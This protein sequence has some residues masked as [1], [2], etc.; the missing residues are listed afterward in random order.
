MSDTATQEQPRTDPFAKARAAKAAKRD[1]KVARG[2]A[3]DK[4]ALA[5]APSSETDEQKRARLIQELA[6]LP[7]PE[8]PGGEPGTYILIG[9]LPG[10]VPFTRRWYE[11]HHEMVEFYP[12]QDGQVILNGVKY[13]WKR[14]QKAKIPAPHFGVWEDAR[15]RSEAAYHIW[16]AE[17]AYFPKGVGSSS[18]Y[19]LGHGLPEPIPDEE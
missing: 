17:R 18:I 2:I 9:G 8:T 3:A 15:K 5:S 10:K 7:Q 1:L 19:R 16:D 14:G 4:A 12:D 11:Q 6:D 13:E